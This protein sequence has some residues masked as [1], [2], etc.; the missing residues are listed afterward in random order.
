MRVLKTNC[1]VKGASY[2]ATPG[3]CQTFPKSFLAPG[4][5]VSCKL[6]RVVSVFLLLTRK[7]Q[8]NSLNNFQAGEDADTNW[9]E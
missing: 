4:M 7:M 9:F 1:A 8:T 6:N 3:D 5:R 2:I